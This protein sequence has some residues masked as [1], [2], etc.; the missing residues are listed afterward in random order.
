MASS[1]T[2]PVQTLAS[3]ATSRRLA[4]IFALFALLVTNGSSCQHMLQQNLTPVARVLPPSPTLGQ[5]MEVQNN[6]VARIRSLSTTD[7][8]LSMPLADAGLTVTDVLCQR[9]QSV[10][11]SNHV[12]RAAKNRHY[13][14]P[15]VRR[16]LR[17]ML[18]A[19]RNVTDDASRAG[20]YVV[21]GVKP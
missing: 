20:R 10:L 12:W 7:A 13:D 2:K 15:I 14:L 17:R 6:N 11:W 16:A 1:A 3:S 19:Y 4:A 18:L 8:R 21:K 5:I 9:R